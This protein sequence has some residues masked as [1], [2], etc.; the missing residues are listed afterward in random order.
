M[1]CR[2]DMTV[3]VVRQAHSAMEA[4]LGNELTQPHEV[5]HVFESTFNFLQQQILN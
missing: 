3:E 1:E 4:L 5:H 2:A